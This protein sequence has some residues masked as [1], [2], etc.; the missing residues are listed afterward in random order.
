AGGGVGAGHDDDVGRGLA[1][2][3]DLQRHVLRADQ[4]LVVQVPALLGQ[5]LV[6][7]V[8]R[9]GAGGLEGPD[10]VHDVER[11]AVPGVAVDQH[12]Q[13]SARQLPDEGGDVVDGDDAEVG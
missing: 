1:R 12:G 11:L 10:H 2:R 6:L 5:D 7:D 8:D 9:G 4:A 13:A 3:R